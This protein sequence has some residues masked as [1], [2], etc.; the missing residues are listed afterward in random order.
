MGSRGGMRGTINSPLG[1]LSVA[2]LHGFPPDVELRSN[3]LRT[4]RCG[5]P[6]DSMWGVAPLR[7]ARD[8][9]GGLERTADPGASLGDP[10]RDRIAANIMLSKFIETIY[11]RSSL[12][13]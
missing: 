11:F 13:M 9:L 5:F 4:H 10:R 1:R 3:F 7:R 6:P 8:R 12:R 2:F